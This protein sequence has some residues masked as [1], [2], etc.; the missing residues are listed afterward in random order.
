MPQTPD[1]SSVENQSLV[2]KNAVNSSLV[3]AGSLS[4]TGVRKNVN[5]LDEDTFLM[6][7]FKNK[8][9]NYRRSFDNK[10]FVY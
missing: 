4:K 8:Q 9:F 3:L 10:A 7:N 2:S 5:V 1:K 6:V